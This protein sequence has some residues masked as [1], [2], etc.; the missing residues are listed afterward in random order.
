MVFGLTA[1]IVSKRLVAVAVAAQ[2]LLVLHGFQLTDL[3]AIGVVITKNIAASD[4]RLFDNLALRLTDCSG[5]HCGK[6]F[7]GSV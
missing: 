2:G 7:L 4:Q 1:M 6:W 3:I 5:S